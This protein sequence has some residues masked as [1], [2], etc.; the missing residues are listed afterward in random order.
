[1]L[2]FP[3]RE[4]RGNLPKNMI[5]H[6]EFNSQHSNKFEVL[7]IIRNLGAVVGGGVVQ[8]FEKA[9]H[10]LSGGGGGAGTK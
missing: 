8:S 9:K 10:I 5:L 4:N 1:M 3:D 7:K 2:V 6:R